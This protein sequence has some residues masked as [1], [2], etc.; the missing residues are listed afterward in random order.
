MPVRGEHTCMKSLINTP[1]ERMTADWWGGIDDACKKA[2]FVA[3]VVNM[4][5][6]GFEMTNLSLH[7]DDVA[8][9]FIEDTILGHYLGRFGVGWLYYYTQNHYFMPFL[10]LAEGIVLMSVYGVV[11]A[12]FW[13]ARKAI[14][15]ALITAIVCVFPWFRFPSALFKGVHR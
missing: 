6:F 10:Q 13:G 8:Q 3:V 1:L 12:R 2:F 5:A 4:L 9:I 7:H 11:V 15:I 14:D